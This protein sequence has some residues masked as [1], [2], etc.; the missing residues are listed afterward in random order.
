[1]TSCPCGSQ[2]NYASCCGKYL[3]G[4][5]V[6]V[7]PEELM[8]SRYTAYSLANIPY[9]KKTM[10][11]KPL[12]GFNEKEAE[13]WAKNVVWIGLR[14]VNTSLEEDVG[15]VEFIAQFMES[16][17]LRSIHENSVFH[18]H[19]GAWFYVDGVQQPTKKVVIS[20]NMSCP[21]GSQKKFKNC[22]A[23]R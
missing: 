19:E 15:Y 22:H 17:Y 7:T 11:G 16:H 10:R 2:C 8:R 21:C 4:N 1:M 14:V 12:A 18:K 13:H 3:E 20:R 5:R 6:P 9:V 23:K